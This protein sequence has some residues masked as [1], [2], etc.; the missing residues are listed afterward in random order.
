MAE[1]L[2]GLRRHPWLRGAL[3]LLGI[4]AIGGLGYLLRLGSMG[5]IDETEPLFAEA[6][7][8]MWLTGDWI[9]PYFND[10]TRFDK[11]PLI[12]WAMA[13]AYYLIGVNEWAVRLPSALS[14]LG[15]I[16][17]C[18]YVLYRFG[19][20]SLALE[21]DQPLWMEKLEGARWIPAGLT[22]ALLGITPLLV[23]WGRT[24]VSD[25]LLT[26]CVAG[27][28]LAFFCGYAQPEAPDR[29]GRWYLAF[30]VLLALGTLTKGPVAIVLPG[31]TLGGFLLC[32]GQRGWPVIR[33]LRILRGA[34]V[35]LVLT[36]PWFVAITWIHGMEYVGVFFGYHNLQRFTQVVNQHSAPWYF[37]FGV[38][39]VGALPYSIF[40][41]LSI[42]SL[43]PWRIASWRD[44]P[45]RCH[46]GLLSISWVVSIF[47]FFSVAVTKLPS[48]VLPL[49]PAVAILVGLLWS[50]WILLRWGRSSQSYAWGAWLTAI[51]N[52][53]FFL[54]LSGLCWSLPR[55]I[56][57]DSSAPGLS[58]GILA[59]HL[60]ELGGGLWLLAAGIGLVLVV[61][62]RLEGLWAVN[63]GAGI[64][65]LLIVLLQAQGMLDRERQLPLRQIARQL[66]EVVQAQ[67]PILMVGMHKPS[68]VFYS[69]LSLTFLPDPTQIPDRIPEGGSALL[70]GLDEELDPLLGHS[71]DPDLDRLRMERVLQ[72]GAYQVLRVEGR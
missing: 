49:M 10:Q 61:G 21:P 30:Y 25:M 33:E 7:R 13:V 59:A 8:Q 46:L 47:L 16:G 71:G 60:P 20:E 1:G 5:L 56:G 29:Q 40:L 32:L 43:Y 15:L 24:G 69:G 22:G 48:Y 52:I 36:L 66:P 23:V 38:V 54:V 50:R 34:L 39:A 70:L 42:G 2:L 55:L 68:V 37:Y 53:G 19:L 65:L 14:A 28:V 18:V 44:Q 6:A 64:G 27:A 11:P 26:A 41:P 3:I 62:R 58:E 17:F 51:G 31:L 57:P 63:L 12:Y 72:R 67:E 35:F 45:R 9:T 4:G